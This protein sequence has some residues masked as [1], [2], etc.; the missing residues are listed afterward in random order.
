MFIFHLIDFDFL[1][2]HYSDILFSFWLDTFIKTKSGNVKNQHK[3]SISMI[4]FILDSLNCIACNPP[5]CISWNVPRRFNYLFQPNTE[6]D[7][8]AACYGRYG[9]RSLIS[10]LLFGTSSVSCLL[11][12]PVWLLFTPS[13]L[14]PLIDM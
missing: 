13:L 6:A 10:Q 14:L 3:Y 7:S 1:I 8:S 9:V 4:L 2:L 11:A 12:L 5:M